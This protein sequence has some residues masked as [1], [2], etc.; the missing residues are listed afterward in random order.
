[1]TR[2]FE[3]TH[4]TS[5]LDNGH[6]VPFPRALPTRTSLCYPQEALSNHPRPLTLTRSASPSRQ[7]RPPRRPPLNPPPFP[8]GPLRRR[9]SRPSPLRP[10]PR[11]E[12]MEPRHFFLVPLALARR[13]DVLQNVLHWRGGEAHRAEY[14]GVEGH[15]AG[16]D[17]VGV[18]EGEQV[19]W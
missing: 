7:T 14:R 19:C 15:G 11:D 8:H 10:H 16:W 18:C 6:P 13:A 17:C 12:A 3:A 4:F 9:P 1:M 2:R 5:R